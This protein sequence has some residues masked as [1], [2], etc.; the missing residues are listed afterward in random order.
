MQKN[1]HE[2]LKNCFRL[3]LCPRPC[4]GELTP[5][6]LVGWGTP[7]PSTPSA[8]RFVACSS[9]PMCPQPIYWIRP[10]E[11]RS[12]AWAWGL[13]PPKFL[14]SSPNR[15]Q[16]IVQYGLHQIKLRSLLI[17]P[18]LALIP[19]KN[20]KKPLRGMRAARRGF[21]ALP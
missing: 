7:P 1:E 20:A 8:S 3:G 10:C 5:D 17:A 9:R 2:I 21:T 18:F 6:P 12:Q 19:S 11:G 15:V 16:P 14:V 13:K 4:W